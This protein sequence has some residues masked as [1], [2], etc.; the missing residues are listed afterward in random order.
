MLDSSDKSKSL[1]CFAHDVFNVITPGQNF[2]EC[3]TQVLEGMSL[4]QMATVHNDFSLRVL[5]NSR[6]IDLDQ[7]RVRRFDRS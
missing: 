2:T 7:L 1:V 3:Y 5:P 6:N 4:M